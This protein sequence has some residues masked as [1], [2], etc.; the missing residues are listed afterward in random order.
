MTGTAGGA[1]DGYEYGYTGTEIGNLIAEINTG[2]VEGAGQYAIDNTNIVTDI[3][4]QYW[5]GEA[6]AAF[7]VMF[8]KDAQTFKDRITV[9]VN[10]VNQEINNAGVDYQNFDK[11]LMENVQ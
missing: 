7:E 1:R 4:K 5:E 6:E 11:G 10:A 8:Q 9:L 2:A 3:A